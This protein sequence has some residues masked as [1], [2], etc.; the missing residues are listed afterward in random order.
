M[1]TRQGEN[2]FRDRC[3][4]LMDATS[5]SLLIR[6]RRPDEQASWGRFVQLY[7]P[8]LLNW[9]RS[10]GLQDHDAADLVQEVLVTLVQKLA[11]FQYDEQRG[12]RNWLHTVA[13]NKFRDFCR[14]RGVRAATGGGLDDVAAPP[15][16]DALAEAE[17]RQHLLGRALQ[18]MQA[19]FAPR[20][21][22]ACWEH[23]VAGR[24]VA[25][26][27]AELGISEGTVYVA[28]SRVMMRL[29]QELAGLLD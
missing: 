17:Y 6:L 3:S 19:E 20:M 13:L 7:T 24:A 9:A 25:E 22:K 8:L 1:A 27:A 28:K 15:E 18:L 11:T 10:W 16:S 29:R 21:W 26:V 2:D 4:E 14:R 12:F 5:P 23:V